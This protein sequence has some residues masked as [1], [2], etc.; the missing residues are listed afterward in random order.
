MSKVKVTISLEILNALAPQKGMLN[1]SSDD[2]LNQ[3]FELHSLVAPDTSKKASMTDLKTF[4][5]DDTQ[6]I[7]ARYVN[8]KTKKAF[9]I[10]LRGLLNLDIAQLGAKAEKFVEGTTPT[11]KVHEHLLEKATAALP[12]E[13][14]ASFT[15]VSVKDREQ[16][17]TG[18]IMYPH[19][20]YQEFTDAIDAL[21]AVDKEATLDSI[22]NDYTF[23]Q[24]LYAKERKPSHVGVEATKSIVIAF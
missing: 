7:K 23:M 20:C 15:V 16:I 8:T 9:L 21:R 24:G 11:A 2:L 17:G 5:K 6:L 3:E 12:G 4:D 1:A 19:Y 18:Y 14:P 13:L 22:Y 10:P